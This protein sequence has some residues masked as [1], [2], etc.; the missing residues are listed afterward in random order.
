MLPYYGIK[1]SNCEAMVFDK[2]NCWENAP[3]AIRILYGTGL[4]NGAY[5]GLRICFEIGG[6]FDKPVSDGCQQLRKTVDIAVDQLSDGFPVLPGEFII[7][8]NNF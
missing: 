2:R 5:I 7:Y 8:S 6:A 3:F 1:S 4:T